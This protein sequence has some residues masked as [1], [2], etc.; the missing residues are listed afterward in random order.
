MPMQLESDEHVWRTTLRLVA[1]KNRRAVPSPLHS[2]Y[3]KPIAADF[4]EVLRLR[5]KIS[6][7]GCEPN[8]YIY[9]GG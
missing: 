3:A 9:I 2:V 4:H 8:S 6:P 1:P 5:T 7:P